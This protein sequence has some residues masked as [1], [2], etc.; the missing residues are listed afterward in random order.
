MIANWWRICGFQITLASSWSIFTRYFVGTSY[1]KV[2]HLTL[3]VVLWTI[4]LARNEIF[5]HDS[6]ISKEDFCR[7]IRIRSFK[8]SLVNL[9]V[10]DLNWIYCFLILMLLF[11]YFII[12]EKVFSGI[13]LSRSMS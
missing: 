2:W 3:S 4:W 8:W 12:N 6:A 9:R 1:Q 7:L 5:F 11:R 13:E 10:E